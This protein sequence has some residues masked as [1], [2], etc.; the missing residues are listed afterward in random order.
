[1]I[2][3]LCNAVRLRKGADNPLET[4]RQT[5]SRPLGENPNLRT[6]DRWAAQIEQVHRAKGGINTP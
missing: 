1:M 6:Q 2:S 5:T 3:H 4:G